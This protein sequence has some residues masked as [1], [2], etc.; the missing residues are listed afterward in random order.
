MNNE[1]KTARLLAAIA[2]QFRYF[3]TRFLWVLLVQFF[4]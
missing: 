3:K 2:Y 4:L 1:I